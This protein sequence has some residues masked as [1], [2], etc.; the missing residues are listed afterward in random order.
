MKQFMLGLLLVSFSVQLTFSEDPT[1]SIKNENVAENV[2]TQEEN[3]QEKASK[4][5]AKP[6]VYP[7]AITTIGTHAQDELTTKDNLAIMSSLLLLNTWFSGMLDKT[8]D[9]ALERHLADGY[10]YFAAAAL[11]NPLFLCYESLFQKIERKLRKFHYIN[12]LL[13]APFWKYLPIQRS[14]LSMISTLATIIL[15]CNAGQKAGNAAKNAIV[16]FMM[17]HF[18]SRQ[19]A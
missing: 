15:S 12:K 7:L 17:T 5:K 6:K 1:N 2:V 8:S 10:S 16:N 3:K 14:G 13:S 9:S 19:T 18:P 11:F 4:T